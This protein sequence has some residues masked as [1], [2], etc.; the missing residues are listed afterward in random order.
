MIPDTGYNSSGLLK[1]LDDLDNGIVSHTKWLKGLH[2]SLICRDEEPNEQDIEPDAHHN[3]QFG[4]WYYNGNHA[5]LDRLELFTEIGD[6]H[7]KMHDQARQVLLKGVKQEPIN[8][9]DYD[10]F[11]DLAI[12]FKLEVRKLQHQIIEEVCVVDHL[13][14]A[15]NRQSMSMRLAQEHERVV[16]SGN[17]SSIC[18][19]DLDHFKEV[20][21]QF[22]HTCGDQVLKGLVEICTTNLRSYD[23]IFRYG[24]EEFL[25]CLP[26]I[27]PVDAL[28]L[29]ERLREAI[30]SKSY[31]HKDGEMVSV[32]ASFGV[33]HMDQ[34]KSL[35]DVVVE[36]DQALLLA[37]NQGRNC[38]RLWGTQR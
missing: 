28:P 14:G 22:G 35:D 37:K 12:N 31:R 36:A 33:S 5:E 25:I 38:I 8:I 20:N 13:T 27:E 15:W 17:C 21:D 18:M 10:T 19:L 2:R 26:D 11:M 23:S 9:D 1:A 24:G 16:R 7:K 30:E 32:T 34:D 6:Q 3:C 4:K 29:L